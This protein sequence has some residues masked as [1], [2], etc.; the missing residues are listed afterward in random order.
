MP[1]A[2]DP[3]R[4]ILHL[5]LDAFFAAVE[6]RDKPSLR[7]RPV[8]VGGTGGR[9]VVSTASYE[10]R[11]Y[12][13]H[14][15]MPTAEARRRAPSGTAFLSSRFE[16]Y[17]V[18][19]RIV[20]DILRARSALVEQVSVDE[21][22]VDLTAAAGAP[23]WE[24]AA[25]EEWCAGLLAEIAEATGG[26]TASV[27]VATSKMMAKLAS[28]MH[29]PAGITILRP[30]T[31]LEVLHPMS[32][33]AVAGVGP[34][35]AA[36]L[37]TFGVETVGDLARVS[38]ADLVAIFGSAHG[39]GLHRLARADDDRAVVAERETKS[40]SV[41][42]T[43]ESDIPDRAVLEVEL[44][45]MAAQLATRM[46]AS[47]TFARTI[48]VKA[49][50]HDFSTVTR[51][52]SLPYA[53]GDL[54]VVLREGRRLLGSIDVS[55]GLRLLGLGVSGL[56]THAQDELGLDVDERTDVVE[57][58]DVGGAVVPEP[59]VPGAGAVGDGEPLLARRGRGWRT[60]QDVTHEEH[61][62]GWVWGSGL[63]RVTVRF[64]GP[65][66]PPGP[67]RTFRVDD[68]QLSPATPPDWRLTPL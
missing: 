32:V 41:E 36:R 37:R 17:R 40:V 52:S 51:S 26:L 38:E 49:R 11:V 68:P 58:P 35:T 15:A 7:G 44:A 24:E 1:S 21:A 8:V 45:R 23:G 57:I 12:G 54:S 48:T 61:G 62:A 64:E 30:G 67:I 59:Q 6:Q 3:R 19:S 22:Y 65:L 14:S 43:F 29:K 9:G 34:A 5:D 20:M 42:E 53:T 66:T 4:R 2:S 28:E 27:G 33:R 39:A 25:L 16:A 46:G 18:S 60:G 63:G 10:A 55:G 56:T 50:F 13:V 47:A 31:E